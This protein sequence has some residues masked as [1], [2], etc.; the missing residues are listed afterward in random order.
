MSRTNWFRSRRRVPRTARLQVEL[1]ETRN[2]MS[3]G[4]TL[5]PLVRVSNDTPSLP[6]PVQPP[7]VFPNSEV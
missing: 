4:L 5:T 3:S 2:L 1:L 7:V 6:T